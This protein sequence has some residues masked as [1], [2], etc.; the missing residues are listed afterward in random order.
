MKKDSK[1]WLILFGVIITITGC[2][3]NTQ[4]CKAFL[5]KPLEESPTYIVKLPPNSDLRY[6]FKGKSDCY[7]F[8]YYDAIFY[9]SEEYPYYDT[10]NVRVHDSLYNFLLYMQTCYYKGEKIDIST[11]G[12]MY[13]S[14]GDTLFWK[15]CLYYCLAKPDHLNGVCNSGFEHLYVGYLHASENDTVILNDYLSSAIRL[16]KPI[17]RHKANKIVK[18]DFKIPSNEP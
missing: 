5:Y 12:K 18:C 9:I 6:I 11:G 4:S 15:D 17:N 13:V 1:L 3:S 8:Y 14:G 7:V 16:E 2:A 10:T